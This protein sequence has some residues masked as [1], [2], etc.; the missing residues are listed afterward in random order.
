MYF[1]Y[2]H[3]REDKNEPFYVGLGTVRRGYYER[4][5]VKQK[6]GKFWSNIANKTNYTVQ[7]IHETNCKKE[8]I[9]KEV[10]FI[11]LYGRK[12]DG[13]TL[14][15]H[16]LGGEGISG[17]SVS[18]NHKKILREVNSGKNHPQY[19]T[20]ASK[21]TRR[22]QSTAK[23]GI[24]NVNSK[25]VYC[26]T[27]NKYYSSRGEAALDIYSNREMSKKISDILNGKRKSY[28]GFKFK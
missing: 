25:P 21:E 15:N 23:S 8:A 20:K 5:Y 3:I 2:R 4:A 7:I 22:K 10:E 1:I 16:T 12:C 9:Q 19:G 14:V 17:H 6:R 27:N 26:T 28:L 13:G 24:R 18:D 11:S